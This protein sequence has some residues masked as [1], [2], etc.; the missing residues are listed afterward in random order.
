MKRRVIYPF[1]SNNSF[2]IQRPFFGV[3]SNDDV[4]TVQ[5]YVI[6]DYNGDTGA[7]ELANYD[8]SEWVQEPYTTQNENITIDGNV[9]SGLNNV[10]YAAKD[11]IIQVQTEIVDSQGSVQTQLDADSLGYPPIL[12]MPCVK[13]AGGL[14]GT[15]VDEVYFNVTLVNGVLTATGT[16]PSSGDWK[17]L[18][19]RLNQSLASIGADWRIT[20]P[21]VTFLV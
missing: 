19:A 3:Y 11:V 13:F 16:L 20:R 14:D 21:N 18:E 12:K 6:S 1:I 2:G 7:S 4:S 8:P 15:V 10:Y 17:L 5:G 9:V